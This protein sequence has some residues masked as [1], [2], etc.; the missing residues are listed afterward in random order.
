MRHIKYALS[1]L[2]VVPTL[3]LYV[4]FVSAQSMMDTQTSN[5][6]TSA[7]PDPGE[8]KGKTIYDQLQNKQTTCSKLTD[9]GFADLGDFYMSEMMG[10]THDAMDQ[11]MTNELGSSGDRQVHIAMGERLSGCDTNAS[12]PSSA[13]NYA[14]LA[15]MGGMRGNDNGSSWDW[16]MMGGY[17]NS[18]WSGAD[19]ALAALLILAVAVALFAWLRPRSHIRAATSS[20]FGVLKER[21]AKGEID[22][23]EFDEKKKELKY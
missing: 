19:T 14:P 11:Y 12:Y 3:A 15:W 5:T 20:A 7:T 16:N 10:S 4:P 18:S 8:Q 2:A 17:A 9:D 21:Y 13:D 1:V 22:K 23:E 6:N